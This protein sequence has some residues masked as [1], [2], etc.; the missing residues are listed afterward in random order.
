MRWKAAVAIGM[1]TLLI[2]VVMF[3][4]TPPFNPLKPYATSIKTRYGR[5][6]KSGVGPKQLCAYY[7]TD[8]AYRA[9][10]D[11][12][13][14]MAKQGITQRGSMSVSLEMDFYEGP[15]LEITYFPDGRGTSSADV[16]RFL[17]TREV[18]W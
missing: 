10:A 14:L 3:G 7:D 2:A 12:R 8:L 11:F 1:V 6:G 18:L 17:T 13:K 9:N 4:P 16:T 5:E 15:G